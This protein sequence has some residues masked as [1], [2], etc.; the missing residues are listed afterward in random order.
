MNFLVS[1]KSTVWSKCKTWVCSGAISARSTTGRFFWNALGIPKRW[2]VFSMATDTG[3][4]ERAL[5]PHSGAQHR[6]EWSPWQGRIPEG[7]KEH[8]IIWLKGAIKTW[9]NLLRPLLSL[10]NSQCEEWLASCAHYR[11]VQFQPWAPL[12]ACQE[13]EQRHKAG[14]SHMLATHSWAMACY[15][16]L[17]GVKG[18]TDNISTLELKVSG[19]CTWMT[20]APHVQSFPTHVVSVV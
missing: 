13:Q 8:G 5:S 11:A 9:S 3:E 7:K 15:S 4:R 6:A 1:F 2:W 12:A 16:G 19:F 17:S 10:P 14:T 20:P 18:F